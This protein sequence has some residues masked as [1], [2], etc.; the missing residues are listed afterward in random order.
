MTGPFGTTEGPWSAD[1]DKHRGWI[2]TAP[3]DDLAPWEV[4]IAQDS[5]GYDNGPEND[6]PFNARAI[7]QVPAMLE[8]VKAL[9]ECCDSACSE[10]A[11][12]ARK[13]AAELEVE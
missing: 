3:D 10:Y 7:A 6:T 13:I 2:I 8:L 9:A 4:A 5:C 1:S 11:T 12:M